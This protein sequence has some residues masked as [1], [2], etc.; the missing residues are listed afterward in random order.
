MYLFTCYVTCYPHQSILQI[1][2][3]IH[4]T[5][6]FKSRARALASQVSIPLCCTNIG[7]FLFKQKRNLQK[8]KYSYLHKIDPQYIQPDN[9]PHHL[10]I[11]I[12]LTTKLQFF[13]SAS[14]FFLLFYMVHFTYRQNTLN[15]F[16]TVVLLLQNSSRNTT[17]ES[18]L[19]FILR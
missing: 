19:L 16:H 3:Y 6:P 9:L 18:V 5:L 12:Q 10:S 4:L 13:Q 2:K 17:Q 8:K 7:Y 15:H 1:L 11:N 14:N